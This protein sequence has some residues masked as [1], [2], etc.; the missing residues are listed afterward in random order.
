MVLG[1]TSQ[2]PCP[3]PSKL[4]ETTSRD[5]DRIGHRKVRFSS[6]CPDLWFEF[7]TS[8][9]CFQLPQQC[10]RMVLPLEVDAQRRLQ[11]VKERSSG[12][13]PW[14]EHCL[15]S[16]QLIGGRNAVCGF[17]KN[18]V[19]LDT[20][21]LPHHLP[22]QLH[23]PRQGEGVQPCFSMVHPSDSLCQCLTS[24]LSGKPCSVYF[25]LKEPVSLPTSLLAD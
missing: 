11:W 9:I 23:V 15:S 22:R 4:T 8:A 7:S 24:V 18:L 19:T 25:F 14:Q 6:L 3:L 1:P 2:S 21:C 10:L 13:R 5:K 20:V 16:M 12:I 17:R